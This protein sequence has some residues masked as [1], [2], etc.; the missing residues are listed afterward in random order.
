MNIKTPINM[1]PYFSF[2]IKFF[3][4]ALA[5]LNFSIAYRELFPHKNQDM[6]INAANSV[7]LPLR[8]RAC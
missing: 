5:I 4:A 7:G 2:F 1:I 6:A 3:L 8:Q